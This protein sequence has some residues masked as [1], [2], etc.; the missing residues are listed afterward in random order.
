MLNASYA[1]AAAAHSSVL[2]ASLMYC[3]CMYTCRDF[4]HKQVSSK[5][6]SLQWRPR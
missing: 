3:Q 1:A 4:A 2:I 5:L 6:Y